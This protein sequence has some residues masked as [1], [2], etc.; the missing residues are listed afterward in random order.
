LLQHFS[1][2][3]VFFATIPIAGLA[4]GLAVELAMGGGWRLRSRR[5]EAAYPG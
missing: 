4:M 1:W 2:S 5:P 3:S